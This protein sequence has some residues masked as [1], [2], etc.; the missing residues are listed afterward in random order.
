MVVD[1]IMSS[2]AGRPWHMSPVRAPLQRMEHSPIRRVRPRR[3]GGASS[4]SRHPATMEG[5]EEPTERMWRRKGSEGQMVL[6]TTSLFRF[7][8]NPAA[9]RSRVLRVW[10]EARATAPSP[11]EEDC[12]VMTAVENCVVWRSLKSLNL[13]QR[14]KLLAAVC[15][16]FQETMEGNSSRSTVGRPED[17][18]DWGRKW[19][20]DDD[21]AQLTLQNQWD[22]ILYHLMGITVYTAS[23]E[24]VAPHQPSASVS[25]SAAGEV[26]SMG[27]EATATSTASTAH[28][29]PDQRCVVEEE[30]RDNEEAERADMEPP[31]PARP[32]DES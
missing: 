13:R 16:N 10:G 15:L 3:E 24:G 19:G 1:E 20:T 28:V 29:L 4:S 17:G 8:E 7:M 2:T 21:G 30:S 11:W 18:L 14:E 9:A 31:E 32:D 25:S 22:K 12:A 23:M 26:A 6:F 27:E 5:G